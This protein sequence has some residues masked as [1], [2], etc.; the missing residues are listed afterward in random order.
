MLNLLP[1]CGG[2]TTKDKK[3]MPI[4]VKISKFCSLSLEH[5]SKQSVLGHSKSKLYGITDLTMDPENTARDAVTLS[6]CKFIIHTSD[7]T[8]AIQK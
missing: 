1:K 7:K 4:I 3:V 6:F 2:L 8:S 5:C